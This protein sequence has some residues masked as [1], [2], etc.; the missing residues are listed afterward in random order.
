MDR[1]KVPNL[2]PLDFLWKIGNSAGFNALSIAIQ[3]KAIVVVSVV[4]ASAAPPPPPPV[5]VVVVAAPAAP[6]P[7]V[8]VAVVVVVVAWNFWLAI[9]WIH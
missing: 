3:I 2:W 8:V 6:A 4:V 7:V 9:D 1:G 5:A